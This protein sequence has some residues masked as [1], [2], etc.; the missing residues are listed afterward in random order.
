[1][2]RGSREA[3][4][5]GAESGRCGERS[6]DG[7]TDTGRADGGGGGDVYC[8]K[9]AANGS[10]T[11]ITTTCSLHLSHALT[12]S[13][14]TLPL[15][16]HTQ[17]EEMQGKNDELRQ[18]VALKEEALH[19]AKSEKLRADSQATAL[20]R[21]HELMSEKVE[22]LT[23]QAEALT[24][25]KTSFDAQLKK[26]QQ[27]GS[28]KEEEVRAYETLIQNQKAKIS[29]MQNVHQQGAGLLKQ[30]QEEAQ[31]AKEREEKANAAAA[32]EA[33]AV[34]RMSA[35]KDQVS[36]KLQRLNGGKEV[37]PERSG[38]GTG[39]HKDMELVLDGF[40]R[41]VKCSLCRVNDKDAGEC[42]QRHA[43]AAAC[44]APHFLSSHHPVPF[45]LSCSAVI[46]KC[47]HAFCR[48]CIQTRLDNRDRKCPACS[49]QFDYQSV[50]DLYL[51]S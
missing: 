47:W 3:W 51:T 25:L 32:S 22:K 50:K 34:K 46:T 45:S 35:E 42:I 41:K 6:G 5:R 26:A 29:E 13:T 24:A 8:G 4:Y 15:P 48:D 33:A 2:A 40:R 36:R 28:K 12:H 43:S 27:A 49:Q 10:S 37:M 39:L 18:T 31:R 1:M 21:E 17:Y 16:T 7:P 20:K 19:R 23:K 38:S 9:Q 44:K 14:H 11:H 30:A